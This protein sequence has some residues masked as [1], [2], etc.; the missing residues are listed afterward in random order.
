MGYKTIDP[1]TQ[2][3]KGSVI[4]AKVIEEQRKHQRM[5]IFKSLTGSNGGDKKKTPTK[6]GGDSTMMKQ[7]NHTSHIITAIGDRG[8][9]LGSSVHVDDNQNQSSNKATGGWF[10]ER[11]NQN[12]H[13]WFENKFNICPVSNYL[14]FL[15][16]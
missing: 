1:H 2:V 10:C 4:P 12:F 9:G 5:K 15:I 14:N 11:L 16:V 8:S 3:L 7:N 6:N 13:R